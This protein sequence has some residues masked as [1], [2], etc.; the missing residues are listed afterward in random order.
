MFIP[1]VCIFMSENT[2]YVENSNANEILKHNIL[3]H[4]CKYER[5]NCTQNKC[6]GI[7]SV[8]REVVYYAN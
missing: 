2:Y 4:V 5:A 1:D 7:C 8:E 3:H 6:S